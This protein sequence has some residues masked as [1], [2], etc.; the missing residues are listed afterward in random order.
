MDTTIIVVAV[1]ATIVLLVVSNR[2]FLET[3]IF[4][5]LGINKRPAPVR[6]KV[7]TD[8]RRRRR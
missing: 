8:D 6:V 4:P 3:R 5:L 7:R 2:N 1:I